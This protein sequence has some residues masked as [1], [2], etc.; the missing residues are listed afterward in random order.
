M[1]D[2]SRI[3]KELVGIR[4]GAENW[5]PAVRAG[6]D[7]AI[8]DALDGATDG[9]SSMWSSTMVKEEFVILPGAIRDTGHGE[10][11]RTFELTARGAGISRIYPAQACL[12]NK[13]RKWRILNKN[14]SGSDTDSFVSSA[15]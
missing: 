11:C 4:P 5:P 6:L 10:R 7:R 14:G 8:Q 3:S 12:S 15:S 1:P 9:E 2:G 13:D